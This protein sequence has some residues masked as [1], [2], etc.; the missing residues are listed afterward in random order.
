M[1]LGFLAICY[2]ALK[3]DADEKENYIFREQTRH[4][5]EIISKQKENTSIDTISTKIIPADS[6]SV[7]DEKTRIKAEQIFKK[8]FRKEAEKII[9]KIYSA[10]LMNSSPDVFQK[11]SIDGST[12][13]DKI[14]QDMALKYNMDIAYS[15]RLS[16][17]VI[18]ELTKERMQKMRNKNSQN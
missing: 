18:D 16:S 8:E 2:T 15:T 11:A 7:I 14:Q 17:E 10:D 4:S 6:L 13:L 3:D 1:A 12:Q 9:N 5:H